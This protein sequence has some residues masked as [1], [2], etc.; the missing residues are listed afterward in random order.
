MPD[1]IETR[2]RVH[3]AAA[4]EHQI[5]R[6]AWLLRLSGD[7]GEGEQSDGRQERPEPGAPSPEPVT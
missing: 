5:V 6:S 7:A 3:D 1:R 2:R 4:G